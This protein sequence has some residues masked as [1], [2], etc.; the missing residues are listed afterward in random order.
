M[1]AQQLCQVHENESVT[2][3][4]YQHATVLC[5]K[6]L[7]EKHTNC[8]PVAQIENAFESLNNGIPLE[9]I[10]NSIHKMSMTID[11][12]LSGKDIN[13]SDLKE[14][15]HNIRQTVKE[16]RQKMNKYLDKLV[17]ILDVEINM[18]HDKLVDKIKKSKSDIEI[19][20]DTLKSLF[21]D[22]NSIKEQSTDKSLHSEIQT[23]QSKEKELELK[24]KTLE[25]EDKKSEI[26]VK[27]SEAVFGFEN[28]L[29]TMGSVV[30]S[31]VDTTLLQN[32]LDVLQHNALNGYNNQ[33]TGNQNDKDT[34]SNGVTSK[35]TLVSCFPTLKLGRGVRIFRACFLPDNTLLLA[36]YQ[37]KTLY[38]CNKKGEECKKVRIANF[39]GGV[40][41]Y[42][43]T[44]ALVSA[45]QHGVQKI[46]LDTLKAGDVIKLRGDS[47]AISSI[48]NEICVKN[49]EDHLKIVDI[50]GRTIR[51]FPTKYNPWEIY[52][53]DTGPV[54]YSNLD[55]ND[56]YCAFPDGS[57][58]IT[59]SSPDL[60][61][62]AGLTVDN[63]E[64]L[65]ITG[66]RSDNI[67]R[68][69]SNREAKEIILTAEDGIRAP[70][71][72]SFNKQTS[73]LLIIN[74][75]FS[76]IRIYKVLIVET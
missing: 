75:D 38:V 9:N 47:S 36:G 51:K 34:S 20:K 31:E 57:N 32:G 48:R 18:K 44:C 40:T 67:H 15:R 74:E 33:L 5:Q 54:F 65:Y 58:Y 28:F 25:N 3:F 68:I 64:N 35:L 37:E 49:G 10:E 62:P 4:C 70:S 7:I 73:E 52:L 2:S 26:H 14:K 21:D 46:N 72:I 29:Q 59:Y 11:Q 13:L 66:S 6:C 71:G 61:D 41:L 53:T 23:L 16:A 63:E 45:W 43:R 60:L 76:S 56:V 19:H 17:K 27:L 22:I 42:S 50:H 55:N 39:P 1:D 69:S 24:I 30:I 8:R 12:L